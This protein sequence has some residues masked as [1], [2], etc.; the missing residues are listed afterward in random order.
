MLQTIRALIADHGR[1]PVAVETLSNGQDLY[2]AGLTSF[3]AVQL[4]LALEDA[5]DVEFPEQ[6]LNRRS[7]ASI[8]AI[9]G[10]LQQLVPEAA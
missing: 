7:F 4:M 9:A 10:C 2:A 1:L 3:A 6:M 8:D 5:F